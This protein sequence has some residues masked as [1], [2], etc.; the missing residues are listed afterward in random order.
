MAGASGGPGVAVYVFCTNLEY[1]RVREPGEL[2]KWFWDVLSL[3]YS[4]PCE[5]A[6]YVQSLRQIRGK[7]EL[8]PPRP[9]RGPEAG[10]H[11]RK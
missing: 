10:I 8:L 7:K 6:P 11:V 9:F 5:P 4:A 2:F 1:R 3:I